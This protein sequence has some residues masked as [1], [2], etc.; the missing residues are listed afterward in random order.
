MGE[1]G[2]DFFANLLSSPAMERTWRA[3]RSHGNAESDSEYSGNENVDYECSTQGD[4][5]LDVDSQCG[6]SADPAQVILP[7]GCSEVSCK[8]RRP[9]P[10]RV[11]RDDAVAT[12]RFR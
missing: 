10:R 8:P 1:N 5:H 9:K 12:L 2:N 3:L 11:P 6:V 7:R 4:C